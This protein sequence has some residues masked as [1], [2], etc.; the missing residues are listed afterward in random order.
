MNILQF[1]YI[2]L[3]NIWAASSFWLLGVKATGDIFV[4][5]VFI[6]LKK[7]LKVELQAPKQMDIACFWISYPEKDTTSLMK[8]SSQEYI[9]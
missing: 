5:I 3:L 8:A 2:L 6:S 9:T 4:Y 1:V 7:Y